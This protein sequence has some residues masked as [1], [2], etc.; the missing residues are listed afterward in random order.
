MRRRD[1]TTTGGVLIIL[2]MSLIV[3][4]GLRIWQ[5]NHPTP[6][7]STSQVPSAQE[8]STTVTSAKGGFSLTFPAGWDSVLRVMDGDRFVVI[9]PEQPTVQTDTPAAVKDIAYYENTGREVLEVVIADGLPAPQGDASDVLIGKDKYLLSGRKYVYTYEGNDL[10]KQRSNGD[11]DYVY[12]FALGGSRELRVTY[13][14]FSIS[15]TDNSKVVDTIV[16]SIHKLK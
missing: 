16:R 9:G 13:R 1:V 2:N 10:D 5:V 3:L 11:K 14:V 12:S 8:Q 7:Q 6:A 15:P 4:T